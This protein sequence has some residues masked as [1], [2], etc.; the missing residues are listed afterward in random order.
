MRECQSRKRDHSR[1][2][3]SLVE[4]NVRKPYSGANENDI[5][6]SKLLLVGLRE[7]SNILIERKCSLE[8]QGDIVVGSGSPEHVVSGLL[9]LTND[10]SARYQ[11][12]ANQWTRRDIKAVRK[13]DCGRWP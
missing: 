2:E 10:I 6:A 13:L 4:E 8:I 11:R 12:Q 9:F 5:S 1:K 7:R 3:L